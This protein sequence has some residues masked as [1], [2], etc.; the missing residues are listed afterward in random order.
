MKQAGFVGVWFTLLLTF[1]LIN[2]RLPE[3][4]QVFPDLKFLLPASLRDLVNITLNRSEPTESSSEKNP[5]ES[6]KSDSSIIARE[7]ALKHFIQSLKQLQSGNRDTVRILHY[8]DSLLWGDT[9]SHSARYLFQN[10]YG[11]GGIGLVNGIDVPS[12]KLK[13]HN[14]KTRAG[15]IYKQI[16][17]EV[18]HLP[19]LPDLGF[20]G[21]SI[22]PRSVESKL[23]HS[24]PADSPHKNEWKQV[25][26]ITWKPDTELQT[27]ATASLNDYR[28][29]SEYSENSSVES[30]DGCNHY[31]YD[32]KTG[33][34]DLEIQVASDFAKQSYI[35]AIVLETSAGI[36][37]SPI[38]RMGIHQAWFLGINKNRF[39]CNLKAYQP[40][41][42]IWQFGVNE[43]ASLSSNYKGFTI[44]KYREQIDK[45]YKRIDETKAQSS[46]LIVG[47]FERLQNSRNGLVEHSAQANV[48]KIQKEFAEKYGFA[49]FDT[50]EYLGGPGQMKRMVE[51]G[52]A[53][54][55]YTH[56]TVQGGAKIAEG[57]F[58]EIQRIA[59]NPSV[60]NQ[61]PIT[62]ET[63]EDTADNFSIG[64]DNLM[65]F[66]S[67]AYIY[68]LL[69]MVILAASFARWPNIRLVLFI[70]ASVVFYGSWKLWPV[71]LLLFSTVLDFFCGKGIQESKLQ[72][73]KGNF[74]LI[75]SLLGNL[76]MLFAFKYLDFVI[77]L[78]AKIPG[79][80]DEMAMA[81]PVGLLLPAGISFYTFQTLSYTIDIYRGK[82]QPEQNFLKFALFVS[83][84]PQLVAG[85]IV[86]A[87]DFIGNL[88]EKTLQHFQVN[89]KLFQSG[90]FLI[91]CGMLKKVSADWLAFYSVDPVYENPS[92]YTSFE[93]LVSWY[94]YT[95]QI[96]FDF[97]G[98]TD[99]AIGSARLLGYELTLNFDRPYQSASIGEFWRRWHISLGSWLR[100][101]LYIGL[102]GSRANVYRNLLITMAIAGIWHGA[103]IQFLIWGVYHGVLLVVE[104]LLN[105][106][107]RFEKL[108]PVKQFL[109]FH[110]VLLGWIVFRTQDMDTV[111]SM[112]SVLIRFDFRLINVPWWVLIFMA[113]A[114]FWHFSPV[115][116]RE[117]IRAVYLHSPFV[118][119]ATAAFVLTVVIFQL[120]LQEVRPF[121]YFQF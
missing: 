51:Y 107:E 119:Q 65:Q 95:L 45:I 4:F 90:V 38:I 12:S 115:Q 58:S 43:S 20:R 9:I 114:Y 78:I 53:M 8:G 101:Y 109:N 63:N 37:Y 72:G 2:P 97:S 15:F 67:T 121:I 24:I 39:A 104:R 1:A 27:N 68:F 69:V 3:D 86:R 64:K 11:D 7:K 71:S 84:F 99:I 42:I 111:E 23:I 83:F 5:S 82:L 17:F 70:T 76:G 48:I 75:L 93:I 18:F 33:L 92:M 88:K 19:D 61:K 100:D 91:G 103:G 54:N 34:K 21:A 66:N 81:E 120:N 16:P 13:G 113:G 96:Y 77:S 36:T 105:W 98:Y 29:S 30:I 59:G 52:L 112:F 56:V 6:S 55:D 41:L 46:V 118:L 35:D 94:A 62:E 74:F 47:P 80:P 116:L 60:I 79:I 57:L 87:K 106:E 44:E 31:Q 10:E 117:K 85:P 32:L 108:R 25:R 26:L 73:K 28:F 49:Y 110:L 22:K 50:Y 14:N 40:D 102:G 89:N